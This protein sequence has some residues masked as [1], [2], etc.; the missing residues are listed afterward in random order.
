[1]PALTLGLHYKNN[2][3]TDVIDSRLQGV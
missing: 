2:N 1:M 3:D